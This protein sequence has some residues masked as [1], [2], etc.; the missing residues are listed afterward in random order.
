MRKEKK[1][2]SNT[3]EILYRFSKNKVSLIGVAILAVLLLTIIFAEQISP[4]QY[5]IKNN[6]AE[7]LQ[8]P[9]AKHLFGT[10]GYGRDIFTRVIHGAKYTMIIALTATITAQVIGAVLGALAAFYTKWVDGLLMRIL[11]VFQAIPGTLLAL[12]VV[13]ALG[14]SLPNLV[15]AMMI[16][17][18]PGAARSSR[19]VMLSLVSREDIDA[20]RS[21]GSNDWQL[22]TRHVMPNAMG[23][24]IVDLTINL[25]AITL[26]VSS[27]S[28]IGLGVQPPTPEWGVLLSEAREYMQIAPH[29]IVFPGI[30]IMLTA[31]AFNLIGDGLRDALDPRLRD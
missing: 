25:S 2:L 17:R 23:P 16:S 10:D 19:A 4:Y 21:Y 22:I 9:S 29:T 6:V 11:D 8:G 7:R 20:A 18:I 5:G 3:G 14:T 12:A 28:Y 26:Q 31:L 27:L 15:I 1:K 30:A 24:M 13:A